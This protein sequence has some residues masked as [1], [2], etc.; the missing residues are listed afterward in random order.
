[1]FGGLDMVIDP[2]SVLLNDQRRIV[3]HRQLDSALV[4]GAAM[5]KATSLLA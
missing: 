4:Q 2:Y 1:M 3:V 5:V